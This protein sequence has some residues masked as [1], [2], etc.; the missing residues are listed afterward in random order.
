MVLKG[1]LISN[2]VDKGT[3][4]FGAKDNLDE[5]SVRGKLETQEVINNRDRR[6]QD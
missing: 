4:S 3:I 1:D 5:Q 6:D 2:N